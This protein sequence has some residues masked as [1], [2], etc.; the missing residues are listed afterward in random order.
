MAKFRSGASGGLRFLSSANRATNELYDQI[1]AQYQ[2]GGGYT[3]G[4]ETQLA[5]RKKGALA[6]GMQS[7]VSSGM[8]GTTQAAGL[9]T[10]FEEEVGAPTMAA[11]ETGR[12]GKLTEAMMGKAGFLQNIASRQFSTRQ[13]TQA[14]PATKSMSMMDRW[15]A[16][17]AKAK[18]RSHELK[19]K[20]AAS[21]PS[22]SAHTGRSIFSSSGYGATTNVGSSGDVNK[23]FA[24]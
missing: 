12:I 7:L 2:P 13:T 3:K 23:F 20:K 18:E 6:S 24:S 22:F 21:K 1:I 14:R 15:R 17:T 8:A 9:G 16:D 11:A 5:R 19:M 10:K 4:L